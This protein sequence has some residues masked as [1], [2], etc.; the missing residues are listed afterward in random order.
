MKINAYILRKIKLTMSMCKLICLENLP[1][2]I[3]FQI[4]KQLSL[5][6]IRSVMLSC[7]TFYNL[8]IS[9]NLLWK[10][11]FR[12]KLIVHSPNNPRI[13]LTWYN[14]CRISQN[15][16]KGIFR[17]MTIIHYTRS[18]MPMLQ[19]FPEVLYVSVGSKL[20]CY[21]TNIGLHN[22]LLWSLDVPNAR[23]YDVRTK[24][25]SRFTVKENLIVCGKNDGS[26]A[27][28]EIFEAKRKPRLLKHIKNC[29]GDGNV[30]T[31]VEVI[32]HLLVTGSVVDSNICLLSL[33]RDKNSSKSVKLG[34][35]ASFR[36]F[37]INEQQKKLAIGLIG[38][39]KPLLLDLNM[40]E[41]CMNTN[42]AE[43]P[44]RSITDIH[45]HNQNEIVYVTFT[46]SIHLFDIRTGT[47]TYETKDPI[48]ASLHCVRTDKERAIVVG[49]SQFSHCVLYDLRST[50]H[51]QEKYSPVYS[52][53][54][55]STKLLTT[56]NKGVTMLRFNVNPRT[57]IVQDYSQAF[58]YSKRHTY[59][60]RNLQR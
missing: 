56:G 14:K 55:D 38:S 26:A 19:M 49:S 21:S 27:I 48:D 57:T 23:R 1:S 18:Y 11:L 29:H 41:I 47:I 50:R 16:R 43:D 22:K 51:V 37:A 6:D 58:R 3:L 32:D 33:E 36:S 7:K 10:Y 2:E 8:I 9:D 39:C 46:G 17:S 42:T 15:W 54:F 25:I 12:K 5:Q 28:F 30:V 60:R 44:Y 59:I 34:D 35:C 4:F 24:D 13:T 20:K 52:L 40:G 31:A 53:D 45:W